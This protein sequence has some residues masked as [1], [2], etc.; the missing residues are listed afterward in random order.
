MTATERFLTAAHHIAAPPDVDPATFPTVYKRYPRAGMVALTAASPLGRLLRQVAGVTRLRYVTGPAASGGGQVAGKRMLARPAP[1]A[2]ARYPIEVY[3]AVG[4]TDDVSTGLYHYDPAHHAL[5]RLRTGD[6]RALITGCLA[7]PPRV[8]PALVLVLTTVFWRNCSKYGQFGYR[9]QALDAGV[10]IAQL[11]A[12]ADA[13]GL[14]ATVHLRFADE[15]LDGLLGCDGDAEAVIAVVTVDTAQAPS[16]ERAADWEQ[17]PVRP[18]S[19]AVTLSDRADYAELTAL[20]RAARAVPGGDGTDVVSLPAAVPP[21]LT[22][23]IAR[24][25][26]VLAYRRVALATANLARL[27]AAA[28]R[29]HRGDSGAV[30]LF[31]YLLRVDGVP[32]GPYRYDP[33]RHVLRPTGPHRPADLVAAA[34]SPRLRNELRAAALVVLPVGR[35]DDE[36]AHHGDRW[37]RMQHVG[38]GALANRT[39]LAAAS[40][41]LDSHVT[42]AYNP[43]LADVALG[44]ADRPL[45]SLALVTIGTARPDR[46]AR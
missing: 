32:A 5:D 1:S 23:G 16:P 37:Y 33:A 11:A 45:T 12:V 31:C 26:T 9:L 21:D 39:C 30:A 44:L 46:H 2:G 14:A 15:R 43:R 40:L 24:R 20:H 28:T 36:P 38:A 10:V 41:G 19:A 42:C 8:P 17:P 13:A 6:G 25:R 3:A 7:E 22:A 27:L 34:T 29:P 18:L 4:D 35:L